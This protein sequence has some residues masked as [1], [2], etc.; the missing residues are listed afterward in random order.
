LHLRLLRLAEERPGLRAHAAATVRRFV[1]LRVSEPTQNLKTGVPDLG[2]FLVRFLLTEESQPVSQPAG[3]PAGQ[4]AIAPPL[5]SLRMSAPAIVREILSRNVRWVPR[6]FW[7]SPDATAAEREAQVLRS[8]EAG[9]IGM[10]LTAL[11]SF[12][13]QRSQE[14]GLDTLPAL[15]ACGGGWPEEALQTFCEDCGCVM[16]LNSFQ[17]L[18]PW[19]RLDECPLCEADIHKMLCEAVEDSHKRG[20]NGGLPA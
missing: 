1:E 19:L 7:A 13:M 17:E 2:R 6:C 12:Y 3:L 10:Q 15:E 5:A 4:R 11:L 20:Y 8:F 9:R 16:A 14:L 18:L